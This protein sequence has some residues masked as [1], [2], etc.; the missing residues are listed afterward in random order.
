M[1]RGKPADHHALCVPPPNATGVVMIHAS[2]ALVLVL[3]LFAACDHRRPAAIA[4]LESTAALSSAARLHKE[5]SAGVAMRLRL[6]R[7]SA[8]EF[9]IINPGA[10][11]AVAMDMGL[12]SPGNVATVT[13]L[14]D[15][16]AS[17]YTTWTF[18]IIG[19]VFHPSVHS[20]A[21]RAC[22]IA[23][24]FLT[25]TIPTRD[26]SYPAPGR[27]RFYLLTPSGVRSGEAPADELVTG[28]HRLAELSSAMNNVLT[29]L[30]TVAEAGDAAN[31]VCTRTSLTVGLMIHSRLP[32][33]IPRPAA[34]V[35]V[36][37][38]APAVEPQYR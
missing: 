1:H 29:E 23:E 28:G 19:G 22:A 26:V 5:P 38:L 4:G 36:L 6:L 24:K 34:S 10:V 18:G 33:R 35:S 9:G 2:M 8:A 14:A 25:M 37:P 16:N 7:G 21:V 20:A 15:G 11:W 27:I 17:L 13:A 32:L 30:R 12:S 3:P 31:R